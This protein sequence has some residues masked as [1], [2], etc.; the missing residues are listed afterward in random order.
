MQIRKQWF[1]NFKVL[2]EKKPVLPRILYSAKLSFKNYDI[3][4][5]KAIK[6]KQIKFI[7]S[8]HRVKEM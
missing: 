8:R 5:Y 6:I 2:K 3:W 7:T 4:D 1:N